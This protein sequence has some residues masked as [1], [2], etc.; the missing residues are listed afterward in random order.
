MADD[1]IDRLR[2]VPLFADLPDAEVRRIAAVGKE[3]SFEAGKEVAKE[4][5]TG[6]GFH[7]ILEGE[8]EVTVGEA[9]RATLGPGRYFGEMSLLDGRPR[10]A[11]VRVTSPMRTFSLTSWDF[12]P[13]VDESP[14]IARQLLVEL[15]RRLREEQASEPH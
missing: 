11:T 1:I 8:A 12:L 2:S 7:L 9:R 6:I 3:V 10:S 4:G 14:S 15:C 13:I 5:E